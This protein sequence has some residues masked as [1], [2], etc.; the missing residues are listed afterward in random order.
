[1]SKPDENV[2]LRT[3]SGPH[4]KHQVMQISFLRKRNCAL[5]IPQFFLSLLIANFAAY[6]PSGFVSCEFPLQISPAFD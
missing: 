5:N 2:C 4:G 1:M 3:G 6:A